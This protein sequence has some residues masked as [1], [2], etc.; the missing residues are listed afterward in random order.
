MLPQN[1]LVCRFLY[2]FHRVR[3]VE[4]LKNHTIQKIANF[5]FAVNF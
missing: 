4:I 5:A 2:S 1:L 3:D